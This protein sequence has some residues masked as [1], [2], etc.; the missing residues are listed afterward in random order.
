MRRVLPPSPISPSRERAGGF[1][2]ASSRQRGSAWTRRGRLRENVPADRTDGACATGPARS[3]GAQK[4]DGWGRCS[5]RT[6]VEPTLACAGAPSAVGGD[7]DVVARPP[8]AR[9]A[10]PRRASARRATGSLKHGTYVRRV[11]RASDGTDRPLERGCARRCGPAQLKAGR[12]R[13]RLGEAK[14]RLT[15]HALRPSAGVGLERP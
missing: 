4:P 2:G 5:A 3:E 10:G 7:G 15:G 13:F 9:R 6:D 14:R 8:A 11:G 12:A 1:A